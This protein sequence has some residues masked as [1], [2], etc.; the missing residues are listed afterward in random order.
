MITIMGV[1]LLALL[2]LLFLWYRY[3]LTAAPISETVTWGCGYQRPMPRMQYSASSFAGMLTDMFSFVLK[4]QIHKT[5]VVGIFPR[6]SRFHSHV[7]ESVL[8]LVYIPA[9][10]RLYQRFIPIRKLQNGIL[11]QYILYYL[12]TLIVLF[13]SV[14]L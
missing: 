6:R 8:E 5:E 11:Q 13:L 2:T 14:Y 3:R 12:I 4:P 10:E 9:L 7:P 1:T